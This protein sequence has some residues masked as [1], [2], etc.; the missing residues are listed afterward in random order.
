MR[1][2]QAGIT[3]N[4]RVVR[5]AARGLR[6]GLHLH[7]L[8]STVIQSEAKNLIRVT[9]DYSVILSEAK[10]PIDC[11]FISRFVSL[12]HIG[13]RQGHGSRARV[14]VCV[15]ATLRGRPVVVRKTPT[16]D[17]WSPLRCVIRRNPQPSSNSTPFR[18]GV[19][20]AVGGVCSPS[21]TIAFC[22]IVSD[23]TSDTHYLVENPRDNIFFQ[24][25]KKS[26]CNFSKAVA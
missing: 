3:K 1:E 25:I 11:R 2:F 7:A 15:G 20:T 14:L 9:C 18:K 23:H 13:A 22:L 21:V 10:N 24:T 17:Q 16:G 12:P 5:N 19:P 8:H 4:F 6:R 26:A